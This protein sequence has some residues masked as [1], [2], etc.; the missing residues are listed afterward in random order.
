MLLKSVLIPVI[1]AGAAAVA[2]VLTQKKVKPALIP[3]KKNE[4]K[5]TKNPL[6]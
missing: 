1:L 6:A 5:K 4:K 2:I 3:V